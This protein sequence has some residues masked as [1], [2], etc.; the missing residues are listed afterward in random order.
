[1]A[2]KILQTNLSGDSFLSLVEHTSEIRTNFHN[3]TL[4]NR[5]YDMFQQVQSANIESLLNLELFGS[6]SSISNAILYEM[7]QYITPFTLVPGYKFE[8]VEIGLSEKRRKRFDNQ[9]KQTTP[10][11]LTEIHKKQTGSFIDSELIESIKRE[12]NYYNS[13]VKKKSEFFGWHSGK[14]V[15]DYRIS[16]LL[17]DSNNLNHQIHRDIFVKFRNENT[18]VLNQAAERYIDNLVDKRNSK[19]K[20]IEASFS[21]SFSEKHPGKFIVFLRR[22]FPPHPLLIDFHNTTEAHLYSGQSFISFEHFLLK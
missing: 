10:Y 12:M 18:E 22:D 15:S 19:Y 13:Y 20:F 6:K 16:S 11:S 2:K 17:T 3:F 4:V 14:S 5:D 8:K 21:G 9:R 7:Y 1:M